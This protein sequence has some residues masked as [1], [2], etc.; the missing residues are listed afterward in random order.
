MGGGGVGGRE[1]ARARTI[2][3][4]HTAITTLLEA[5]WS[6]PAASDP[7]SCAINLSVCV[8]S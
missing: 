6:L 3:E 4:L 5:D 2:A 8:C 7:I 1:L